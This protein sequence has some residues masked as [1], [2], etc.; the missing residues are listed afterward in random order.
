MTGRLRRRAALTCSV[1]GASVVAL[2]G[3]VLTIAQPVLQRDLGADTAQVQWT[4]TGYLVAVAS[5]LVFA[6][7]LGDRYGHRRIFAVGCAGFALASAGIAA[8]PGIG[9]VVALRVLQGVTG[10][11]LQPATLGMLRAAYPPERL[12]MPVAVRTSAIGLAAAAGPLAGGALVDAYGWRAVFLI[13]I[14]PTLAV[15]VL[16]LAVPE[17]RRTAG[18]PG[19]GNPRSGRAAE[20]RAGAR[21][22]REETTRDRPAGAPSPSAPSPSAPS[23]GVPSLRVPPVPPSASARSAR[24][25]LRALDL[26]GAALLA[27]ALA[28]L[29]QGLAHGPAAGS[30]PALAVAAVAVT[31]FVRHERRAPQPLLPPGMLRPG[32]VAAGLGALLAVS[33]ALSGTLFTATYLLQDSLGLGPLPTALRMVPLA[34]LMIV[35]APLSAVLAKRV[36]ARATATGGALLLSLGVLLLARPEVTGSGIATGS[37]AALIGAGFGA[38]MVTATSVVVHRAPE[39]HAGVAGGLQQTAMNTGPVLGVALA[40]LLLASGSALPALAA[41]AALAV[42]ATLAL[43][44]A[45][46]KH[47][48]D[49]EDGPDGT[50]QDLRAGAD[51]PTG[52]G[53]PYGSADT[54]VRRSDTPVGP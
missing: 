40:S 45:D 39:E 36:G 7:R 54:S 4:S 52:P 30:V 41:V 53:R 15:A 43:P 2:D 51:V 16:C 23:P 44:P 38:V 13:G 9:W 20:Q 37:A 17:P 22:A 29:V 3:T 27:L 11:L 6:G 32:P 46:R 5:L 49:P 33:A 48:K 25:A 21:P 1:V 50:G 12:G 35:G 10:A 28:A 31:A 8:A 18:P 34:L 47:G 14:V 19:A 26:P 24:A 42:P